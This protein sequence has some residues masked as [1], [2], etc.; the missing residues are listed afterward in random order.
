MVLTRRAQMEISQWLP[1]EIL[2]HIIQYSRNADQ[3]TLARVS[4]LFRDLCLPVLY[5]VVKIKGPRGIASFCS[6]IRENPPRA[7]AVRSFTLDAPKTRDSESCSDISLA[8]LKL[9]LKLNHLSIS[10]LDS[11]TCVALEDCNFPELI[12]CDIRVR[13]IDARFC[14]PVARFLARHPTLKRLHLNSSMSSVGRVTLPNLEF[15][16]GGAGFILALDAISLKEVYLAWFSN[17][18]AE[19]IIIGLSSITQPDFPVISS[20]TSGSW[21]GLRQIVT[22]L[23]KHMRHIKTLRLYCLRDSFGQDTIRHITESLPRFTGLLYL[24]VGSFG[25][26]RMLMSGASDEDRMA[27]EAW[28]EAC[29]TLEACGLNKRAWRK[30]DGRLQEFPIKEFKIL[31]GLSKLGS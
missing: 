23:S 12:S 21:G 17:D 15:Y 16:E 30:I 3:A 10:R 14:D 25:H 20:H 28:G 5:R 27:A 11:P 19:K 29:P 2:V 22:S 4:T 18:N 8:P 6:A 13:A 31:A 26:V 7:D 9:M 24:E 1:N